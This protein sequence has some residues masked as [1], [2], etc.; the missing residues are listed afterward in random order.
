MTTYKYGVHGI[1]SLNSNIPY[2]ESMLHA[3]RTNDETQEKFSLEFLLDPDLRIST[4]GKERINIMF[5]R[6]VHDDSIEFDYPWLR[7]I[8][9]KLTFSENLRRYTFS[10]N[11]NYFRVSQAIGQGWRL[12]SIFRNLLQV[13]LVRHKMIML[14]GGVV[15]IG[16]KGFLMPSVENTGKTTTVWM[17]AKR[18]AH[19]VTD[20]HS[21]HDMDGWCYGIPSSSSVTPA[22]ARAVGLELGKRERMALALAGLKGGVLTVHFTSGGIGVYPERFFKVSKKTRISRIVIIQNGPDFTE[23]ISRSEALAKI[24]AIQSYEFSW[25]NDPYLLARSYFNSDFDISL[26]SSQEE[27][28]LKGILSR[29]GDISLVSSSNREHYKAIEKIAG[30]N[31]EASLEPTLSN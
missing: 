2:F 21:I 4:A 31:P 14:H 26:L 17:L 19:F 9:A 6:D 20:E 5:Y 24:K 23:K 13:N 11:K 25:R 7:P 10:F 15:R 8:C 16:D 1:F 28:L 30:V 3:F 22:T 29:P 12:V 27:D 18:G